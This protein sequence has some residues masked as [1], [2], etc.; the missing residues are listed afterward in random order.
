MSLSV[1]EE[2]FRNA[3]II[4]TGA[5]GFIGSHLVEHLVALGAQVTAVDNLQAG[6]WANL[7]A[8]SEQVVFTECDVRDA[9]AIGALVEKVQPSYVFHLAANASVPGSVQDPVYDFEA[10]CVGTFRLL[11]ALRGQEAC[12]KVV[13]ASSGAVYGQPDAFPITEESPLHP[14]SPYGASKLNTEITAQMMYRVYQVPIVIA[15]LFNAYGP[16]MA[17]FVVLDFLKK[18]QRNPHHLEVLGTG[19]QIRDFTYVAD[20]VQGLITLAL[21]GDCGVA[22]NI[23]SGKNCSVTELAEAILAARGLSGKTHIEYTGTS[24]VGDAQRWEVS[25][26]RLKALGYRPRYSLEE[27][28]RETIAWF[29]ATYGPAAI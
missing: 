25:I 18:L 13:V 17:R 22:Y 16:R 3:P 4:V 8:V 24:W 21:K 2:G 26:E 23:S 12:R 1:V 19:K 6:S 27:G 14:I 28:L 9:D 11:N 7:Q 10:N 29:D 20:T 15:R 5:A